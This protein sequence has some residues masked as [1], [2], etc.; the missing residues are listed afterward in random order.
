LPDV[1]AIVR[2]QIDAVAVP[3]AYSSPCPNALPNYC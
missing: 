3:K 2:P 1:T